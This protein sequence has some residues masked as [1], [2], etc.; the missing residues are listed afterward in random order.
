MGE[1]ENLSQKKF[2]PFKSHINISN[3]YVQ[4]END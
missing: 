2:S 4:D 3:F 1:I